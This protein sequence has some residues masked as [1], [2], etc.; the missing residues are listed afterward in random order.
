MVG[1][2]ELGFDCVECVVCVL[3]CGEC[4]CGCGECL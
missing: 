2:G 4:V 3:M 1:V